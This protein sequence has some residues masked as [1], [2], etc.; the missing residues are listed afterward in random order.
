MGRWGGAGRAGREEANPDVRSLAVLLR[1]CAYRVLEFH[2]GK[3]L[4]RSVFTRFS[5]TSGWEYYEA[6]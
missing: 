5:S 2:L 1:L 6:H 4:V 3:S